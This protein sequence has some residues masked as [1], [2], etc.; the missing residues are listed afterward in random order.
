MVTA[1]CQNSNRKSFKL[2]QRFSKFS[3]CMVPKPQSCASF[4]LEQMFAGLTRIA[5]CLQQPSTRARHLTAIAEA[6]RQL[7]QTDRVLITQLHDP[8]CTVV[9]ES[10]ADSLTPL[11]HQTIH[12]RRMPSNDSLKRLTPVAEG[13]AL[14]HSPSLSEDEFLARSHVCAELVIPILQ[15][16]RHSVPEPNAISPSCDSGTPALAA[17]S[18]WGFIEIHHCE[19]FR[20]WQSL[21]VQLVQQ[22]AGQVAIALQLPQRE[23]LPPPYAALAISAETACP[24]EA[25]FRE[26]LSNIPGAIYRCQC[27]ADW[28]MAYISNFVEE[29][30]GYGAIEFIT[31]QQT[32]ASIIHPDDRQLV[33]QEIFSAVAAHQPFTLEYRIIHRDGTIRWIY[34]R[35]RG[36]FSELGNLLYLDGAIFDICDRKQAEAALKALNEELESRVQERTDQLQQVVQRLEQ[37]IEDHIQVETA[38]VKSETRFKN[39][40]A[41]LPGMIY[42]FYLAPDGSTA[43]PYVSPGCQALYEIAPEVAQRDAT[44]LVNAVHQDDRP[45]FFDSIAQSAASLQPWQWEGRIITQS[46]QMK[47]VEGVSKPEQKADGG[48]LWDGLLIDV[49]ARKLAETTLRQTQQF[50]ESVL[51]T[52]PVAVIAKDAKELRYVLLNPAASRV[53]C[54]TPGEVLG[55]RDRDLFPVAQA[56]HLTRLDRAALMGEAID[57]P[58]EEVQVGDETRIVRTQRTVIVDPDGV[59]EYILLIV[60][61]ITDRKRAEV[62]LHRSGEQLRKQSQAL[63]EFVRSKTHDHSDLRQSLQAILKV[64]SNTLEVSA[65]IWLY[66]ED[67]T[68]LRCI[69]VYDYQTQTH[70]HGFVNR[71]ADYPIYFQAL[72]QER[73]IVAPNAL[74]DPRM[75]EF[76][77]GWLASYKVGAL[78][79]TSIWLQG[80]NVGVFYIDHIGPQRQWSLEEISFAGSV[81]DFVSSAMETWE[82]RKAKAALQ[83]SQE[84]LRLVMDNIPQCIFWKDRN[85]VYLGCNRRQAEASG[86]SSPDDII[87]KTDF[88]LPWTTEQAEF[89]RECDRHVVETNTAQYH[90]IETRLE[91]GGQLRWSDTNKIPLHNV[92][93]EVVGILGTIEDITDR[94]RAE[95]VLR[96]SEQQMRE[97]AQ[98]ERLLNR[99]ISQIRNSLDFDTILA[100]TLREIQVYLEIDRCQFAWYHAQTDDPCWEIV[101]EARHPHQP[102]FT[103][104]Y[105]A[106]TLGALANPL[107]QLQLLRITD[108][109]AIAYPGWQQFMQLFEFRSLLIIPMQIH[110][111]TIGVISCSHSQSMRQ[112]SDGEV[113]LLQSIMGQLAIALTQANLYAQS[114]T[115]AQELE[116]ALRDLQR[117]QAQMIQSEK[118]S[119]LGQL[120]A[121]VA[122]EINNPVNFIYGNLSYASDYTSALLGLLKL[123]QDKYPDADT[124]LQSEAAAIDLDFLVEDLPRLIASM[125]VGAERIQTIVASLRNFS[126]M[127]EA[128]RKSVNIHEGIDS[129]LMIL[130]NRIRARSDR[131][132]I[133]VIK[134]YADLP[135][136]ECYAGQLNQVFM[137]ILSNAIDALDDAIGRKENFHPSLRIQTCQLESNRIRISIADNGLGI[138][139]RVKPRLF[140]PFFTTKAI[141]RGTGMGLSISYQIVTEKHLGSLVCHSD[142]GRGAEFVIEIP[143]N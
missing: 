33:E 40:A 117:T 24:T 98:R 122:H 70:N 61:D 55:K 139:E 77:D 129:T 85:S 89:Y 97:Q 124:Q 43:F 74:D 72:Q 34:E 9:A 59:P 4:S 27:D 3:F 23:N 134:D 113:E 73:T 25:Q 112:W 46:G 68:E 51:T 130:Q 54:R 116:K 6:T 105:S 91:A 114:R 78:M 12:N 108:V 65:G 8:R 67:R 14:H 30:S 53:L 60:E 20:A 115:K 96:Q 95:E 19:G 1:D 21:E 7:L 11:L 106:S 16:N 120:V 86:L 29:L 141:G 2:V 104:R 87:G 93:G 109:E 99:L 119:S 48:I 64:A 56:D 123:Y 41:N 71:V 69:D 80:E 100:T 88:E 102:S 75:V 84:M 110:S 142:V 133:E 94:K 58:Q 31:H 13:S 90:I 36:I 5:L 62:A 101:K 92:A 44:S 38:L 32:W 131:D 28:T 121:G 83:Q 57:L 103:G 126:R 50:V 15:V 17:T 136:V 81:A 82:R 52:L 63:S 47:W 138:P 76:K 125:R 66:N 137:N 22:M 132:P 111:E 118:M 107:L 127:D 49:T 10:V 42:Q 45:G 26:Q 128:E 143:L 140:D 79:D 37:E 35:G 18:T 39:L 135:L